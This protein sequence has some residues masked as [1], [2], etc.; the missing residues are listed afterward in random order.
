MN[1]KIRSFKIVL[2]W[3]PLG[4]IKNKT[5]VRLV[6]SSNQLRYLTEG[7][8]VKI[9]VDKFGISKYVILKGNHSNSNSC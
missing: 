2:S 1:F 9:V 5:K 3:Y 4:T 8:R 6:C 7:S